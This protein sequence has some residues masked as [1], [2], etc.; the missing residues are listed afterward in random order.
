MVDL[1]AKRT[2]R[3]ADMATRSGW[4]PFDGMQVT[5]WPVATIVRG[6]LVMQDGE[7]PGPPGG[8][9]VRFAS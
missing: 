2:L 5:G 8:A 6:R 1:K 4:T 3:H 9:L 7:V